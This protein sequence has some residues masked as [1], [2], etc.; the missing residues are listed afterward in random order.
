MRGEEGLEIF[1]R[2][3]VAQSAERTVD[4]AEGRW[5]LLIQIGPVIF[6][7][8]PCLRPSRRIVEKAG[9]VSGEIL[10]SHR[11]A[12]CEVDRLLHELRIAEVGQRVQISPFEIRRL[13][14]LVQ[15][16]EAIEERRV[17]V[18]SRDV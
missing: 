17:S 10:R 9:Q 11:A 4:R 6:Y 2:L 5:N 18:A 7:C 3:R 13:A 1:L 14:L 16:S 15:R 8:R 12:E